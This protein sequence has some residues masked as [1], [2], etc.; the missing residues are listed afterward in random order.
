MGAAWLAKSDHGPT[1]DR[2][3]GGRDRR[4]DDRFE[5]HC[6]PGS[7]LYKGTC[8]PCEMLDV[9]LSGCRMRALQP[10]TAGVLESVKVTFS[11]HEMVLSIWGTTQWITWDRTVGIRFIYPTGRTRNELAGLLTCL[12]DQSATEVVKKAVAEAAA[13]TGSSLIALQHPLGDDPAPD[14]AE[15]M[16]DEE[17]QQPPPAPLIPKRVELRSEHEV[18][19]LEAG[20]SPAMVHLVAE[21]TILAGNVLDVSQDGC[22]VRLARP[23]SVRLNAQAE[24]DFRLR[25][26]PFILPGTTKAMHDDRLVEIRFTEMSKRKRDDLSQVILELIMLS[27]AA[28][29]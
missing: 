6:A 22:L 28:G 12:L 4:V 10:F 2:D 25:G 13:E 20:E 23:M 19:S 21:G 8:I 14:A 11:I 3:A 27:G 24:V 16:E 9:S 15:S 26:L 5:L 1:N 17:F 18:L 7:L 29:A